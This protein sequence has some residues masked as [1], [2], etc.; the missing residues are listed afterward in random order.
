MENKLKELV[1]CAIKNEPDEENMFHPI[2]IYKNNDVEFI[3]LAYKML[4]DDIQW[5]KKNLEA[6]YLEL[7]KKR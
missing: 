1:K 7:T 2:Q 3:K 5:Y 6:N 4:F